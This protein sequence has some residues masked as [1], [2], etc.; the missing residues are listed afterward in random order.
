MKPNPF[1][2]KFILLSLGFIGMIAS[3]LNWHMAIFAWLTPLFLLYFTRRSKVLGFIIFFVV[4][5]VAGIISRTCFALANMPAV[6]I[7]NGVLYAII[8]FPPYLID[9]LIYRMNKGFYSSLIFPSAVVLTEYLISLGMGTWG[10][11]AH[12]QYPIDQ[13]TQVTSITGLFGLTF[14]VSW[15]GPMVNWLIE[16]KFETSKLSKALVVFGS[17]LLI[18]MIY[19]EIRITFPKGTTKTVK[20]AAITSQ[21]DVHSI[22]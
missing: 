1:L 21:L 14:L 15:L 4:T 6:H 12:T 17:I 16:N 3:G 2:Q 20:V 9:R 5:I 18:V 13:F 22:L 10:S 19:G 7:A 11:V 8:V